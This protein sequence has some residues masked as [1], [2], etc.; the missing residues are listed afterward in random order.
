MARLLT[1]QDVATLLGY[2]SRDTVYRLLRAGRLPRPI[3]L[4][5]ATGHPRWRADVIDAWLAAQQPQ[6]SDR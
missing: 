6:G 2:E 5:G 1:V 4:T 3:R